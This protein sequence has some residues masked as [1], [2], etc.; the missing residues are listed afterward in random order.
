[1]INFYVVDFSERRSE[2]AISF[3]WHSVYIYNLFSVILLNEDCTLYS[4]HN[5]LM[6]KSMLSLCW[7]DNYAYI[8]LVYI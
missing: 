8:L 2:E 1:M 6:S 3:F 5:D 4:Y 7:Y